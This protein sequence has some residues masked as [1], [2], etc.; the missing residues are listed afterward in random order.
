MT[1]VLAVV[2][3][4]AASGAA[5]L[6]VAWWLSPAVLANHIGWIILGG[7]V[8]GFVGLGFVVDS[9]NHGRR[10]SQRTIEAA[11]GSL[12]RAVGVALGALAVV[13]VVSAIGSGVASHGYSKNGP[14]AIAGCRWSI[15]RN[16]SDHCVSHAR[17]LAV[18]EAGD[19]LFV[20]FI[21]LFLTIECA[22]FASAWSGGAQAF[23]RFST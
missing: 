21:G 11:W 17:W 7:F 23:A 10:L 1:R 2:Y 18:G 6:S 16:G 13:A 9:L 4:V 19:R 3:A 14:S 5:T 8:L 22:M 12:P 15:V 20:G